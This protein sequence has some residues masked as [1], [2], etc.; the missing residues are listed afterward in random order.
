MR[1]SSQRCPL[2]STR[3]C[4]YEHTETFL[5]HTYTQLKKTSTH[6]QA[7][8]WCLGAVNNSMPFQAHSRYLGAVNNSM[9]LQA[10]SRCLRA[11]G[12]LPDCSLTSKP[13]SHCLTFMAVAEQQTILQSLTRAGFRGCTFSR[14]TQE[15]ELG[16]SEGQ[17]FQFCSQPAQRG[18]NQHA[19]CAGLPSRAAQQAS[20]PS[21]ITHHLQLRVGS[22]AHCHPV[23]SQGTLQF[24]PIQAIK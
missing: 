16:R 18:D 11:V 14:R 24:R 9:P 2:S 20:D 13:L 8:S 22:S 5:S 4:S 7:H 12:F 1:T 17:E 23:L 21:S 6:L 3:T 10:H 19:L 15:G